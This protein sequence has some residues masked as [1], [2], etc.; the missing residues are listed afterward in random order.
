ME[1]LSFSIQPLNPSGKNT[2]YILEKRLGGPQLIFNIVEK[3]K[4]NISPEEDRTSDVQARHFCEL[5]RFILFIDR[6]RALPTDSIWGRQDINCY[7]WRH[8]K[9]VNVGFDLLVLLKKPISSNVKLCGPGGVHWRF[10][11]TYCLHLQGLRVS[12]ARNKQ[13]FGGLWPFFLVY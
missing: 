1:V 2:Q 7:F 4:T 9:L 8:W 10:E 13:D 12:Q 6:A 3:T 5:C 11:G